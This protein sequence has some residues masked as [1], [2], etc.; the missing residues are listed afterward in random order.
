MKK[1]LLGALLLLSTLSFSQTISFFQAENKE[2]KDYIIKRLV[3]LGYIKYNCNTEDGLYVKVNSDMTFCFFKEYNNEALSNKELFASEILT[4][5]KKEE[6]T[7][8]V[9]PNVKSPLVN[10]TLENYFDNED[11]FTG[12][13][14]YYS[15]MFYDKIEDINGYKLTQSHI[16]NVYI[17]KIIKGKSSRQYISINVFGS[18]LNYGCY[19]VY[20]LFDNGKKIIR[21]NEKIKTTYND[22]YQ[23]GAFFKP[24]TNEIELLKKY[25]IVSLKLYIYETE[26]DNI[27]SDIIKEASNIMLT[28]SKKHN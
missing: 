22:G 15:P 14:T 5:S 4:M 19:G 21:P 20:I 1:L 8:W 18:T 7:I 27:E 3:N 13:K 9:I 24:T 11:K 6:T 23:Y 16:N 17:T 26:I 28:Q 25:R 2:Q 10:K 12:E